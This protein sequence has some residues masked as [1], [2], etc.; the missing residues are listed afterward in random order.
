MP[1]GVPGELYMAGAG[2]ARGYLGLADR[3]AE[4]FLPDP[5]AP[6]PGE[7]MYA[8]GDVV[9][10]RGD[11]NLVFLGRVDR[12]V[13]LR[14]LRVEL[15]E[16]E[17]ALASHPGVRQS[18]VVV[19][20]AGTAQARL[21]GYLVPERG[22]EV[23]PDQVRG[24]VADRLPLHMIPSSLVLLEELPLT[25]TG[26][27]DHTRLPD[28][29]RRENTGPVELSTP[30]QRSL[31]EIWRSLLNVE[32]GL[33]GAQDSFFDLGGNSLQ[34]TQLISRIR[35]ALW[36]TLEPRQ[37]FTHPVLRQL[38]E[39]ID[40]AREPTVD[41]TDVTELEASIA[42]LSEAELDRLLDGAN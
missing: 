28:I 37:L 3:T 26:K 39:Q 4:K 31:A 21:I 38:A 17:H 14:G 9:A 33:I 41:E 11:G 7:R 8:T 10:W 15:G 6:T 20:E 19:K 32:A 22:H 1:I 12:Q 2:L 23:D 35:D 42:E 16:I 25:P 24:Y 18:T 13:K 27:L 40:L 5:Y 36:V 30:T 34:V 29:E